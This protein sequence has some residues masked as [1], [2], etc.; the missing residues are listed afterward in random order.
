[1]I[2]IVCWVHT[3]NSETGVNI[4]S[5]MEAFDASSEEEAI[6]KYVVMA[7][8]KYIE[9]SLFC[10]PLVLSIE[11]AEKQARDKAR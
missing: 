6:G 3:K 4:I 9:H 11:N 8:T 2:Y 1:M 5:R 7:S 10:K